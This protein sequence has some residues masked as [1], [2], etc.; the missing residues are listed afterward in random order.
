MAVKSSQTRNNQFTTSA[1]PLFDLAGDTGEQAPM[2]LIHARPSTHANSRC[3]NITGANPLFP[4]DLRRARAT[5]T[6]R[7]YNR[8]GEIAVAHQ[9]VNVADDMFRIAIRSAA[10]QE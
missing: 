5:V 4:A 10:H 8:V 6:R 1:S 3:L 2:R 9:N 7:A